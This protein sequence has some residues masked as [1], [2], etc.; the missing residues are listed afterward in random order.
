[1]KGSLEGPQHRSVEATIRGKKSYLQVSS[2]VMQRKDTKL[3]QLHFAMEKRGDY[4]HDD[5][6]DADVELESVKSNTEHL[7]DWSCAVGL[8]LCSAALSSIQLGL[9]SEPSHNRLLRR[10]QNVRSDSSATRHTY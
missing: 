4:A 7:A 5:L 10:W 8:W 1:M 6:T 3:V 9:Q 2:S